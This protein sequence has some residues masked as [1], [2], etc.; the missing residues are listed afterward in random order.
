MITTTGGWVAVEANGVG[1]NVASEVSE[2]LAA[3]PTLRSARPYGVVPNGTGPVEPHE[4]VV[5]STN[6][7]GV[8]HVMVG[9]PIAAEVSLQEYYDRQNE[10]CS[11]IEQTESWPSAEVGYALPELAGGLAPTP[12]LLWWGLLLGLSNFARYEPAAWTAAIDPSTS[13]LAVALERVMDIAQEQIP[14]RVLT[15]VRGS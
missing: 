8:E 4:A 15:A 14:K 12:L 2:C 6:P 9:M 3:Y 13:P 7:L 5:R 11:V 1:G 10:F